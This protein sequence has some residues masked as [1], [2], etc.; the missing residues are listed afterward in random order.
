MSCLRTNASALFCVAVELE[1]LES[2][3]KPEIVALYFR[4]GFVSVFRGQRQRGVPYGF[5]AAAHF[6]VRETQCLRLVFA[7]LLFFEKR[8]NGLVVQVKGR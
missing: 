4:N 2:P 5:V 8:S 1:R 3:L 7:L 6:F